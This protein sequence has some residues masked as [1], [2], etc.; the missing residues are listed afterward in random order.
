MYWEMTLE[1]R[2]YE[3]K[4]TDLSDVSDF[5]NYVLNAIASDKS[6][7]SVSIKNIDFHFE[8]GKHERHVISILNTE[9][10]KDTKDTEKFVYSG[11]LV[12]MLIVSSNSARISLRRGFDFWTI[13]AAKFLVLSS[14]TS[15]VSIT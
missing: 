1:D 13:R 4:E 8:H 2:R 6:Y 11:L 7:T 9:N 15:A 3:K 5:V 12:N 14:C 10:T